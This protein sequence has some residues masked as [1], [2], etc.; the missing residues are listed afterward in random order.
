MLSWSWRSIKL[1]LVS[2]LPYLHWWCTVK[3]KSNV[4]VQFG[5]KVIALFLSFCFAV[6]HFKRSETINYE[7]INIKYSECA[8]VFL[9]LLPDMQFA[10]CLHRVMLP[11]V[12]FLNLPHFS[13]LSHKR[14]DFGERV[15][16]HK[17]CVLSF[18]TMYVWNISHSRKNQR[19]IIINVLSPSCKVPVILVRFLVTLKYSRRIFEKYLQYQISWKSVQWHPELLHADGRTDRRD[20]TNSFT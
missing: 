6:K 20:E 8:S 18:S 16:E 4:D 2:I 5:Q 17:M 9:P 14:R 13:K 15:I 3:H 1:L 11:S 12:A 10:P 19:D 7:T